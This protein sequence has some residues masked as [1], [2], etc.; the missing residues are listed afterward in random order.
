MHETTQSIQKGREGTGKV[1]IWDKLQGL[2]IVGSLTFETSTNLVMTSALCLGVCL[3]RIIHCIHSDSPLNR[4]ME[5]SN[6]RLS[7]S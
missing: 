3:L 5:R 2:E 6:L 4:P 1:S 7:F